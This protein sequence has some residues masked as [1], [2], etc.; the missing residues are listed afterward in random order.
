MSI[1]NARQQPMFML[2]RKRIDITI[3]MASM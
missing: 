2:Q 3:M 1:M